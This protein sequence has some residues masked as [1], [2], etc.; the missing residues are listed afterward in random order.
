M[1]VLLIGNFAPDRQE[2]MLRFANMLTAGLVRHGHEVRTWAP[3]PRLVRLLPHY[4][5]G[6]PA[7][8]VGYVDKFLLFPRHVRHR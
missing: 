1:R 3:E 4:R 8:L 6:G 5:Y 2:S 7:K